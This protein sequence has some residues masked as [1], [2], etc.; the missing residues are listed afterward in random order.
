MSLIPSTIACVCM[1]LVRLLGF[2]IFSS[3]IHPWLSSSRKFQLNKGVFC[4]KG[5]DA[6]VL[7]L[8]T[9]RVPPLSS[10]ICHPLRLTI[11]S[12]SLRTAHSRKSLSEEIVSFQPNT[13]NLPIH[14]SPRTPVGEGKS[15]APMTGNEKHSFWCSITDLLE[16]MRKMLCGKSW[17]EKNGNEKRRS[18]VGAVWSVCAAQLLMCSLAHLI[19]CYLKHFGE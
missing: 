8:S 2:A 1:C 19:E 11:F 16:R 7:P 5:I 13:D 3:Y 9:G 4:L 18:H 6:P 17:K 12:H 14:C 10:K 15:R